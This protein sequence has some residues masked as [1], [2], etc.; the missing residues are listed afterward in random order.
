MPAVARRILLLVYQ[1]RTIRTLYRLLLYAFACKECIQTGILCLTCCAVQ[2]AKVSML[3]G[4]T[5][6]RIS[7]AGIRVVRAPLNVMIIQASDIDVM[8]SR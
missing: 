7:G 8:H 3:G 2:V 5:A 6:G 1:L 4:Y